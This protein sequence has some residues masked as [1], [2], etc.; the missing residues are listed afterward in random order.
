MD[1]LWLHLRYSLGLGWQ[2]AWKKTSEH[3]VIGLFV[4]LVAVG[5]AW[6][7]TRQFGALLGLAAWL[8]AVVPIYCYFVA[9]RLTGRD[10]QWE[11]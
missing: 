3:V 5:L 1:W 8:A 7:G 10:P 4:G 6:L 9:K 11:H 2:D